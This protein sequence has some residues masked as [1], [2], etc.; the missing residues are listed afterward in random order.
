M[1]GF[2]F[3]RGARRSVRRQRRPSARGSR[4]EAA[5]LELSCHQGY[6]LSLDKLQ[7]TPSF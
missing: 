6:D 1:K 7:V 5:Y 4:A 2:L 3:D